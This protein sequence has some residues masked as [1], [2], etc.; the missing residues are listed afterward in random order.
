M[1]LLGKEK[2]NQLKPV[3]HSEYYTRWVS[4]LERFLRYSRQKKYVENP[5]NLL[6]LQLAFAKTIAGIESIISEGKKQLLDAKRAGKTDLIEGLEIGITSN[7]QIVRIIKTI[8][9]GLAWRVLGYDRPFLRAMAESQRYPGSVDLESKDFGRLEQK[10]IEITAVRQ[11]KVILNDLTY[12]LRL[13]DLTEVGEKTIV[14]ESK[15]SG[16]ELKSVYSLVRQKGKAGV[17]KQMK[18]IVHAQIIRDFREIIVGN[19]K[20]QVFELPIEF[21]NNLGE[22]V[23]LINEARDKLYS[24]KEFGDYLAVSCTDQEQLVNRAVKT[25]EEL[26]RKFNDKPGWDKEDMVIPHSNLDFFY[27]EGGDFMRVSTPYSIYPFENHD[28][29]GLM[30]GKL[31]LKTE[32]NISAIKRMFVQ[33]GWEIIEVDID[34]ALS[35]TRRMMPKVFSGNIFEHHIDDT[36]FGIKRGLFNLNIPWYWV[37]RISTEFMKPEVLIRQ[38]ELIYKSSERGRSRKILPYVL[39]EKNVW[40]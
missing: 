31:F 37:I 26:W 33:A 1:W 38:A 4:Y 5:Y 9:D 16:R 30:S 36:M 6:S 12:F 10:A 27:D 32:L 40:S 17:S 23:N 3:L 18:K 20:V 29:M 13:G 19:T 35:K 22:V 25:G 34:E 24:Y 7:R 21:E 8:A 39:G 28:C 11:S 15:K 2:V 14:W